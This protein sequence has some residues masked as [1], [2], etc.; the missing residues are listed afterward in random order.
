MTLGVDGDL[1]QIEDPS[2]S[3]SGSSESSSSTIRIDSSSDDNSYA[4]ARTSSS[5]EGLPLV[6]EP[7]S[8]LL[9]PPAPVPVSL[10]LNGVHDHP[11]STPA[12]NTIV[13][14]SRGQ[15]VK[16]N[17]PHAATAGT[18]VRGSQLPDVGFVL[19]SSPASAV[20]S[21]LTTAPASHIPADVRCGNNT[22]TITSC[23]SPAAPAT[24]TTTT[25]TAAAPFS[26]STSECQPLLKR[27]DTTDSGDFTNVFPEDSDFTSLLREAELAIEQEIYP[28]RI[29]QGSSGSYF[30]K[31]LDKVCSLLTDCVCVYV[32]FMRTQVRVSM[33]LFLSEAARSVSA[34]FCH[35]E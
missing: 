11:A 3:S 31:A 15:Q 33:C 30:V 16:E 24:G 27:M 7:D 10:L 1:I 18:P 32:L 14:S 17:S 22:A 6:S 21:L 25:T 29:V 2:S 8:L 23:S 4:T 35:F 9:P 5:L 19:K 34:D 26:S 12:K 28:E 20:S 13:S